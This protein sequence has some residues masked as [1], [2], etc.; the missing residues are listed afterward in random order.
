MSAVARCGRGGA[1][2][3]AVGCGCG[4]A[5]G[6]PGCRCPAGDGDPRCRPGGGGVHDDR[7]EVP[8]PPIPDLSVVMADLL[9]VTSLAGPAGDKSLL[10]QMSPSGSV[11]QASVSLMSQ[12]MSTPYVSPSSKAAAMDQYLSWNGSPLAG[13]VY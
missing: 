10:V 13:G 6:F 4:T 11:V 9:D 7:C 5:S 3:C 2:V 1:S 12:A 8:V